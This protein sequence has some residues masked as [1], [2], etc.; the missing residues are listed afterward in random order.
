[1]DL[2]ATTGLREQAGSLHA[3]QPARQDGLPLI[4]RQLV[5]H[6]QLCCHFVTMTVFKKGVNT[7]A[8]SAAPFH[9]YKHGKTGSFFR[10]R[11][12]ITDL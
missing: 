10:V 3:A 7:R 9:I 11:H 2:A 12:T 1:M 4:N 8:P 6:P 5:F